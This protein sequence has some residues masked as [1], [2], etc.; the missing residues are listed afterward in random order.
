MGLAERLRKV[1]ETMYTG[2]MTVHIVDTDTI[3]GATGLSQMSEKTLIEDVPCRIS[4]STIDKNEQD[5]FAKLVQE[6][7]LYCD[8]TLSIPEGSRITVTQNDCT[9][10]YQLAGK[11][12]MYM[13]H[14]EIPLRV[15]EEY[16]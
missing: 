16:A 9:S 5:D 10:D 15:F 7:V 13:S 8:P 6:V 4:F 12:G 3:D 2:K 1:Q 11:P 14:Q